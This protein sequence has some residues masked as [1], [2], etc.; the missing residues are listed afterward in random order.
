MALSEALLGGTLAVLVK[1]LGSWCRGHAF[2]PHV[3]GYVLAESFLQDQVLGQQ[4]QGTAVDS[5]RPAASPQTGPTTPDPKHIQ[6]P[7]ASWWPRRKGTGPPGVQLS[8]V[9]SEQEE[10][11]NVLTRVL[12]ESILCAVIAATFRG[13]AQPK[14]VK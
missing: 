14:R 7:L 8:G 2:N 3:A 6:R 9:R 1:T 13:A 4:I 10:A 12:C 11:H 5:E